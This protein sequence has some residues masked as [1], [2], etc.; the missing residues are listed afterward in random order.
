MKI[1]ELV[2]DFEEEINHK[3]KEIK[4]RNKRELNVSSQHKDAM[5]AKESMWDSKRQTIL[6]SVISSQSFSIVKCQDCF[7]ETTSCVRCLSCRKY[8]C[9]SCDLSTHTKQVVCDHEICREETLLV[10]LLQNQFIDFF[11]EI[12]TQGNTK[13]LK[14]DMLI[15]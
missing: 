10:P 14:S 8:L 15:L 6:S 13:Y 12:F 5:R 7:I 11:G 3:K 9:H 2:N 1:G 4:Q